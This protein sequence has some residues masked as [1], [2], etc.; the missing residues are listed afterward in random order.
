MPTRKIPL[1]TGQIYHII[2]R[3]NGSLPIFTKDYTYQKFIS[4]S[5][6]YRHRKVPLKYSKLNSLPREERN[7]LLQELINKK[8][9]QVEILSYCLMP[10]HYHFLLKQSCD[11]GIQNFIRLLTNSY[12]HYFNAK[13]ERKG[14]LFEG[15]FKAVLIQTEEQLLHVSRYIHLNPYSGYLVKKIEDIFSYPYS[16]IGE[17]LNKKERGI[18]HKNIILSFFS[19]PQSFKKFIA[20]RA[21]YQRKIETIKHLILE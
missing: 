13:N 5:D 7:Q 2:N 18:C 15:R 21:D 1:V 3:G 8:D 9:Y 4:L 14:P 12:S 17:Y 16:S 10:T 20:D 6:Y 11:N 19:T